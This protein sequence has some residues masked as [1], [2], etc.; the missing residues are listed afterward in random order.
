VTLSESGRPN[1]RLTAVVHAA[2]ITTVRAGDPYA[3]TS[4]AT[5]VVRRGL[6]DP[7]CIS[8]ESVASPGEFLRHQ[9]YRVYVQRLDGSRLSQLDATFCVVAAKDGGPGVSLQSLN[10]PTYFVRRAADNVIWI[11]IPDVLGFMKA[12]MSWTVQAGL[13]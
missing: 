3:K 7:G 9:S 2:T 4:A 11:T 13:A 1:E 6:A 8:L 12:Q 10:Y 5:F